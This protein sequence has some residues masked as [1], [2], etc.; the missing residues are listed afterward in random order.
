MLS[1]LFFHSLGP[2]KSKI[3]RQYDIYIIRMSIFLYFIMLRNLA[4]CKRNNASKEWIPSSCIHRKTLLMNLIK[5]WFILVNS[6]VTK[7]VTVSSFLSKLVINPY[8]LTFFSYRIWIFLQFWLLF[9]RSFFYDTPIAQTLYSNLKDNLKQWQSGKP[10][11]ASSDVSVVLI[12]NLRAVAVVLTRSSKVV[13]YVAFINS[14]NIVLKD[15]G[16]YECRSV[17]E[18]PSSKIDKFF[19]TGV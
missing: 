2:I 8:F 5:T 15:I 18:Y 3:T 11:D 9:Q 17:I 19:L 14:K 4:M 7:V 6:K 1:K 10:P 13:S 12:A 16:N